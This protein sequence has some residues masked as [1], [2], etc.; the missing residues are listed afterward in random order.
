MGAIAEG[1]AFF[2]DVVISSAYSMGP[3]LL[4]SWPLTLLSHILT[5]AE[6]SWV[7]FA[8]Q[9]I[10]YWCGFLIVLG[11]QYT[12]NYDFKKTIVTVGASIFT[13]LVIAGLVG[14]AYALTA[15]TVE[16]IRELII[17]VTIRA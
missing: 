12:H 6:L 10:V 7:N 17:E 15:H 14:L 2:R 4:F 13:M 5:R 3:Y 9:V 16:F 1:E 11:V 8:N